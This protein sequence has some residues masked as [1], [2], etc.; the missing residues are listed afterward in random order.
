TFYQYENTTFTLCSGSK[1]CLRNLSE[2]WCN[3][4]I[5]PEFFYQLSQI[6]HN[7]QSL[8]IEFEVNISN[9]LKDL[10]SVQKN[11]KYFS[12]TQYENL[13]NISS[14]ITKLPDTLIKLNL[15]EDNHISLSFISK[16]T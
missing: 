2:L 10:I 9:G 5:Y 14:L 12:I 13:E 15:Y 4:N 11:L 6:C 8:I 3:S 1:D 16:F 7:I